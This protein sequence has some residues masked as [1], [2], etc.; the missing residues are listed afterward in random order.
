MKYHSPRA[1]V[2]YVTC[3]DGFTLADLVSYQSKHNEANQ[4]SNRDGEDGNHS[5]N[6]GAEGPSDEAGVLGL[7]A[8][9][10]RN[11]VSVLL[12]A[13]GTP[14]LLMGDEMLRT[15]GGNNNA[16]CQ[17]NEISWM[18]WSLLESTA[19]FHRFLK[20]LAAQRRAHPALRIAEPGRAVQGGPPSAPA[21]TWFPSLEEGPAWD[22]PEVR[23]FACR[24]EGRGRDDDFFLTL[25]AFWEPRTFLLP[26]PPDGRAWL[27]VMDTDRP[28]GVEI[29]AP[30]GE[31]PL[32]GKG[33]LRVAA[34]SVVLLRSG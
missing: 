2:N 14:M 10:V 29:F 28:A 15:Q 4:E 9:R 22:G 11:L 18:D 31:R 17:D 19:G 3:H 16:Y 1:S 7:R 26:D 21:M 23:S 5:W 24:I 25:N 6:S 13:R 20:H 30:G 12:L 32:Q 8:R 34:R 33:Y 27:L